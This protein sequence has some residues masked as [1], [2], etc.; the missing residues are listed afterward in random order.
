MS[1]EIDVAP[2]LAAR[3]RERP[4]VEL[5]HPETR[6]FLRQAHRLSQVAL[7]DFIGCRQPSISRWERATAVPESEAARRYRAVLAALAD[8][9]ATDAGGRPE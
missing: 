5:P 6:R 4:T 7:A 3:R 9:L 1:A 2:L 8:R